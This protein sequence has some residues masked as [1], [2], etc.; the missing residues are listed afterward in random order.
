MRVAP[1]I[2]VNP[3][4]LKVLKKRANSRTEQKQAVERAQIILYCSEGRPVNEIAK[5]M[6]TYP[7]K[8]IEWRNRYAS[9][10]LEGL[11]DKPR[12]GKPVTY[13]DLKKRVLKTLSQDPPKGYG[14]W[15]APLLSEELGCSRDA[16]W[17]V[18]N[19]EGISLLRQRS[20]CT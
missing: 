17:R 1:K 19:K 16:V 15:D 20:W 14:R 8:I 13:V 2:E 12:P 6:G 11:K 3:E 18:L 5:L 4:D 9:E 10:G 7:N